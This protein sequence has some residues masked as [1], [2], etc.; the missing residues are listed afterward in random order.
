MIYVHHMY[1]R[2]RFKSVYIR[3]EVGSESLMLSSCFMSSLIT[4]LLPR[5]GKQVVEILT[6]TEPS[7][8]FYPSLL[9]DSGYIM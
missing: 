9:L 6:V 3:G 5:V 7:L 1:K 4:R 2:W 8:I